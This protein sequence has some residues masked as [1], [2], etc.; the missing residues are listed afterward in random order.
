MYQLLIMKLHISNFK[1]INMK[2]LYDQWCDGQ[3]INLNNF[4]NKLFEAFQVADGI[5]RSKFIKEW[6]EFFEGSENI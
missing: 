1:N 4:T 5:N 6:P 2:C 3:Q